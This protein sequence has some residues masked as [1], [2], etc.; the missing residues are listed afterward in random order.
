MPDKTIC[1]D[2][3]T[4]FFANNIRVMGMKIIATIPSID[5]IIFNVF[6]FMTYL[7]VVSESTLNATPVLFVMVCL[8]S[9]LL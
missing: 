3:I 6:F 5:V 9:T 4:P 7:F 8:A 1:H 2:K